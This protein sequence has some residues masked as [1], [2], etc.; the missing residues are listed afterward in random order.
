MVGFNTVADAARR[1]TAAVRGP[2]LAVAMSLSRYVLRFAAGF[3]LAI[4]GLTLAQHET[5]ANGPHAFY[6]SEGCDDFGYTHSWSPSGLGTKTEAYVTG[7]STGCTW[8]YLSGHYKDG[9][10][11]WHY[12]LGPG[13]HQLYITA[14]AYTDAVEANWVSHSACNPGGTCPGIMWT[15][16]T[17]PP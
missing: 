5:R 15:Y 11:T 3:G 17:Y 12:N 4:A 14:E 6:D 7:T 10:G 16:T 9:N 8:T 1:L 2:K 13:W